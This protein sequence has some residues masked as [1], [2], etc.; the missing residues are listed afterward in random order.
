MLL[1]MDLESAE[2]GTHK[3]VRTRFWSWR[4]GESPSNLVRCSLQGYLREADDAL[5]GVGVGGRARDV[6]FQLQRVDHQQVP[7]ESTGVPRP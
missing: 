1:S 7:C 6:R 2:L 3:T 4:P 5:D